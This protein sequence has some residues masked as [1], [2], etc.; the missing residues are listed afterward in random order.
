MLVT[1]VRT[2]S[3]SL[4]LSATAA[5]VSCVLSIASGS[6]FPITFVAISRSGAEW[7]TVS[8]RRTMVSSR[9]TTASVAFSSDVSAT[10]S[11]FA[12]TVSAPSIPSSCS[13][14]DVSTCCSMRTRK[15]SPAA[16]KISPAIPATIKAI[17]TMRIR[18]RLAFMRYPL[19]VHQACSFSRSRISASSFSSG[20]GSGG[21]GGAC[22]ASSFCSLL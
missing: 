17:P 22:S 11:P 1:K 13:V 5:R 6:S 4:A 18:S 20:E 7:P 16:Q 15:T 10:D 12:V 8:P 14:R 21:G 3:T 2:S 19:W 9:D